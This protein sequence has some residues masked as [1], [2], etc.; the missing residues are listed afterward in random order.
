MTDGYAP[1]FRT[2]GWICQVRFFNCKT[3]RWG[4]WENVT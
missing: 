3:R 2:R 1:Q 4:K